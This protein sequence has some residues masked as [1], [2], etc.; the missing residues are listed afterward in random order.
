MDVMLDPRVLDNNELEAELAALRRGRD[1]A[2]DEGARDVSTADTD[3]L[4]A[5]FE[6]EIRKRHQDSVSDQPSA[7]LP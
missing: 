5:R 4:I 3:H 7:D 6:E 2:M 1:A